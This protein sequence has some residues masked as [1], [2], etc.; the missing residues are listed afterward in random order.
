MAGYLRNDT[1]REDINLQEA[2]KK[3]VREGLQRK[4]MLNFLQRD[5]PAYAWSI[6][7]LDRR[8]RHF[9]IFY[10]DKTITLETVNDAIAKELDGPGQLLGYRAMY[11][12]L[13]QE[14]DIKV[15]RDLVHAKMQELDPDGLERRKVGVKNKKQKESFTTRGPNWVHSLDGHNKLM[16]FQ[17]DT[18][19]LAIYGCV[20]TASRKLLWLRIWTTNKEPKL[21]GRCYL[22][23]LS[24]NKIM[25][26]YLRIDRGTETGVMTTIHAFLHRHHDMD[27]EPTETVIYGPSTANQVMSIYPFFYYSM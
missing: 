22:E 6:P 21:I 27:V 13:R 15:P 9:N 12:K 18:F 8:L 2:L 16:G 26:S 25:P 20:D 7:S 5:Y 17:S 1:W 23:Y 4:E 24:E 11:K 10:T 3:Y 14:H 19:P